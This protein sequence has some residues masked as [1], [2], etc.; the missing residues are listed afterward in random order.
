MGQVHILT[1]TYVRVLHARYVY[2]YDGEQEVDS[3]GD[4]SYGTLGQGRSQ[5]II[6]EGARVRWTLTYFFGVGLRPTPKKRLVPPP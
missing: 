1:V 3:N 6:M 5:P 4:S 2:F